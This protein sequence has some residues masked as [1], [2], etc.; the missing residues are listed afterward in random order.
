MKKVLFTLSMTLFIGHFVAAQNHNILWCDK[1][2][3]LK[4]DHQVV[5]QKSGNGT[6]N[7]LVK[8]GGKTGGS[9]FAQQNLSI[10]N[11]TCVTCKPVGAGGTNNPSQ[12]WTVKVTDVTKP[13]VLAWNTPGTVNYC[14]NGKLVL[15]PATFK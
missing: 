5:T 15:P 3:A 2:P 1:N 14:G 13:V 4:N 9:T 10:T 8:W 7:L 6:L 12:M 11:G